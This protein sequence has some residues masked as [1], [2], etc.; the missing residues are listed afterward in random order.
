V[1]GLVLGFVILWLADLIRRPNVNKEMLERGLRVRSRAKV[2]RKKE[3][4]H[5]TCKLQPGPTGIVLSDGCVKSVEDDCQESAKELEEY[6][7]DG[8]VITL[9]KINGEPYSLGGKLR[10]E[11]FFKLVRRHG[12]EQL[13]VKAG[14]DIEVVFK[15]DAERVLWPLETNLRK[16]MTA[17]GRG[18]VLFFNF[19]AMIICW[20]G[21]VVL[22]WLFFAF[23]IDR[24]LLWLGSRE[25]YTKRMEC[26]L[27]QWGQ[28]T[29]RRLMWVKIMIVVVIY[30]VS[31][32]IMLYFSVSQHRRFQEMVAQKSSM[33]NYALFLSGF[34]IQR[35]EY[36]N[37]QE[38]VDQL[39]EAFKDTMDQNQNSVG[40]Q[41]VGLS[42]CWDYY[43]KQDEVKAALL[44]MLEQRRSEDE[45]EETLSPSG[46][47]S[48]RDHR[49]QEDY[50]ADEKQSFDKA[51]ALS[52]MYRRIEDKF[53]IGEKNNQPTT[54]TKKML[55]DLYTSGYAFL[56]FHTQAARDKAAE[57]IASAG[58]I[59]SGSME[60]FLGR[61]TDMSEFDPE[62]IIWSNFKRVVPGEKAFG[63]VVGCIEI[64][65]FSF[66]YS[67]C[68]FEPYYEWSIAHPQGGGEF[69]PSLIVMAIVTCGNQLAYLVCSDAADRYNCIYKGKREA[70]NTVLYFFTVLLQTLLDLHAVLKS[71]IV[72]MVSTGTRTYD[73]TLVADIVNTNWWDVFESYTV[74][75]RMGYELVNTSA[76]PATF[77]TGFLVE[78]VVLV[79]G[80]LLLGQLIVRTHQTIR[81]HDAE[82][83]LAATPM[84]FTR[85]G[86]L[87]VNM[88]LAALVFLFPGGFTLRMFAYLIGCHIFVYCWDQYR[89]LRCTPKFHYHG[90]VVDR[91]VQVLLSLPCG[92]ILAAIV[93]KLPCESE[94]WCRGRGGN[95]RLI[96]IV[97][98]ILLHVIVHSFLVIWA[99][100]KYFGEKQ[101]SR[102]AE[103]QKKAETYE[104][105]ATHHRAISYF[106]ANPVY[107]LRS[108]FIHNDS[109]PC[110]YCEAGKEHLLE[111]NKQLKGTGGQFYK[112]HKG[113]FESYGLGAIRKEEHKI[114]K[115]MR[116]SAKSLRDNAKSLRDSATSLRDSGAKKLRKFSVS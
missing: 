36:A 25:V 100:P 74:Q 77:L 71:A 4:K 64:L 83:Y 72:G 28:D 85:Y 52:R 110:M 17:A 13:D 61:N 29:H 92:F 66:I 22:V 33:D 96:M 75:R 116:D 102:Q 104:H 27:T 80:P 103:K 50:E 69:M 19:Q 63:A 94:G 46:R 65:G 60:I 58:S 73:G 9:H 55:A 62:T 14:Q 35:G 78:P 45:H 43:S 32:L 114:K 20:A 23:T 11:S 8:L 24:E 98:A 39:K 38:T 70:I 18:T 44:A 105:H 76:F 7:D 82:D 84:D 37:E 108:K 91:C 51:G 6:L 40:K 48:P 56:V 47:L 12:G 10:L 99:V 87:L 15:Q 3:E 21:A 115:T 109:P 93:F 79:I 111:V 89:V 95:N 31:F 112:V 107:C 30:L 101:K 5:I 57:K 67:F 90:Q 16:E 88:G 34:P 1:I 26:F 41:I 49:T 68:F 42:L 81:N 86:D 53:V 54:D 97:G 59:T 113:N 2:R 106:N